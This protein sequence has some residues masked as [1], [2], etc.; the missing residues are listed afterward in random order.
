VIA[1][2]PGDGGARGEAAQLAEALRALRADG[3]ARRALALL[4]DHDSR[5]PAGALQREAML[6]RVEALAG[7]SRAV[8][9]V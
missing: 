1:A 6:A 4:E 3:D 9:Y 8:G 2:A 5:F 7:A